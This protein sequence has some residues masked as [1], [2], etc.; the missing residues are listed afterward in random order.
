MV[1]QHRHREGKMFWRR[2]KNESNRLKL[3]LE[4]FANGYEFPFQGSQENDEA[5]IGIP[6]SGKLVHTK[7]IFD[8]SGDGYEYMAVLDDVKESE[9]NEI[10]KKVMTSNPTRGVTERIINNK[11]VIFGDQD[12]LADRS[13][14]EIERGYMDDIYR[15]SNYFKNLDE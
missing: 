13:D 5:T 12:S 10:A 15:I 3:I 6:A 14:A 8:P 9:I 4:E 11:F 2:K 7:Y 1:Y